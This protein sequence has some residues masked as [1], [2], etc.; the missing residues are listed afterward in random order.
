MTGLPFRASPADYWN[1]SRDVAALGFGFGT[2]SARYKM[3]NTAGNLVGLFAES[4]HT[5]GDARTVNARLYFSK[6]GSTTHGGE[7]LRAYS[8]V[9][10]VEVAQGG[11]VNGAHVTLEMTGSGAA[12][13]GAGNA[14]RASLAIAAGLTPGGTLAGIQIDSQFG[15]GAVQGTAT[16]AIRVNDTGAVG[17]HK[18]LNLPAAASGGLVAA[19]TTQTMTHSIRI[20][21]GSTVLYLMCTDTA[22][23][24]TGGA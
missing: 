3:G 10:G 5:T 13:S 12:V 16:A 8:I 4:E 20:V 2:T 17:W 22:T 24:R 11:T 15:A 19:H 7:C 14:I 1:K 23:N 21:S 9:N 18:L 6:A